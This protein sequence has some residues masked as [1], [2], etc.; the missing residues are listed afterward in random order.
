MKK[1][2]VGLVA[3]VFAWSLAKPVRANE[4]RVELT[5]AEIA[6]EGISLWKGRNYRVTGRCDGLV[7]PYQTQKDHYVLWAKALDNGV[8]VRVADVE[9]GYFD[10]SVGERFTDLYL[11][12]ESDGLPRRPS[13]DQVASGKL[14][15]FGFTSGE[16]AGPTPAP[17]AQEETSGGT[18]TVQKAAESVTASSATVGSV[19]GKI[20]R[21][22]LVI[23]GVVIA[24]VIGTS[25]I[26]RRRGSVSSE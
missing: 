22:L 24:L 25:L 5:G 23:I 11:T 26:F 2:L 20:V 7:Y 15:G 6:C 10:G 18:M 13:S 4:G 21:S 16:E 3:V 12:A 17:L 14:S 1:M 19:I 8:L 9:T